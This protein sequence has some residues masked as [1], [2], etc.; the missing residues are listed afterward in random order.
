LTREEHLVWRKRPALEYVGAGDFGHAV[1][2][3][4]SDLKTHPCTDN[5]VLNGLAKIGKR[6]FSQL[7][8]VRN[9][10]DEARQYAG[11]LRRGNHY[12]KG[13]LAAVS[14]LVE[15]APARASPRW[16]A[17]LPLCA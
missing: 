6:I 3:M 9:A 4:A 14:L 7:T 11:A 8:G 12:F 13:I 10:K 2:S 16:Q 1:P 5:P 15:T 17:T